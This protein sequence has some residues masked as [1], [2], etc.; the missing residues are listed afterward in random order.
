MIKEAVNSETLVEQSMVKVTVRLQLE[1]K[2]VRK[3][4]ICKCKSERGPLLSRYV[5]V[6]TDSEER[7]VE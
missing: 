5:A 7:N 4:Q 6:M 2:I 1:V 3:V